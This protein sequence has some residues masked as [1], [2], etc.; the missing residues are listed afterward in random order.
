MG[1]KIFQGMVPSAPQFVPRS[2]AASFFEL[3]AKDINGT[4]FYFE[5]LRSR[6]LILINNVS[7]D[8]VSKF[9]DFQHLAQLQKD[10]SSR[11]LEI[12]VFPTG[13]DAISD[14]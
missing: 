5:S 13:A 4:P 6:K 12:L 10:L 14:S 1:N 9:Q 2:A 11:G 7:L 3:K 8:K